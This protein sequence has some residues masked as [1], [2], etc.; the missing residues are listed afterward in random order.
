MRSLSVCLSVTTT[1]EVVRPCWVRGN[2]L[3]FVE[4]WR[5]LGHSRPTPTSARA[6][7][8]RVTQRVKTWPTEQG[9]GV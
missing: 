4:T 5:Y 8:E 3:S 2:Q 6:R 9:F 7:K 1:V